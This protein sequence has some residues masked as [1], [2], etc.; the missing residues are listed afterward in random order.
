M[1]EQ[2]QNGCVENSMLGLLS[3]TVIFMTNKL[4]AVGY[5]SINIYSG[6]VWDKDKSSITVWDKDKNSINIYSSTVWDKV[7]LKPLTP[8]MSSHLCVDVC[9]IEFHFLGLR[10]CRGCCNPKALHP[11]LLLLIL[12]N[13]TQCLSI[14]VSQKNKKHI[15]VS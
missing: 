1:A 9:R 10:R 2:K 6:T 14:Q 7:K 5:S 15:L 3:A 13:L 8:Q 4:P 11:F 12:V